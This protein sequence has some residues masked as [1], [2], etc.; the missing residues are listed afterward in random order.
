MEDSYKFE[1]KHLIFLVI[2]VIGFIGGYL[3]KPLID[4]SPDITQEELDEM[5][6]NTQLLESYQNGFN[7]CRD[8]CQTDNKT[9]F[10]RME[11]LTHHVCFCYSDETKTMEIG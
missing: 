2:L 1:W 11:N 9:G 10:L 4:K 3:T 7:V 6:Q 8:Y 5:W